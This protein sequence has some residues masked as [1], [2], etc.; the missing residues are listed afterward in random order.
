MS[1]TK[2]SFN[3]V[4][5]VKPDPKVPSSA[6]QKEPEVL[7]PVSTGVLR[8][9]SYNDPDNEDEY[10]DESVLPS[11]EKDDMLARRTG[12]YQKPSGNQFNAFL[13][14][15]GGVQGKKKPVREQAN[16]KTSGQDKEN[17]QERLGTYGKGVCM[18]CGLNL[19]G[20]MY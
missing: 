13:P 4:E 16:L 15:P 18:T 19:Y 1:K 11:L 3:R 17:T 9:D 5:Q 14:K 12:S 6:A 8:C 10:N 2:H 20:I 7:G